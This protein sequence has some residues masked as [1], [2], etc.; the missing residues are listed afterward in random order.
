MFKKEYLSSYIKSAVIST[1]L[2]AIPMIVFLK[3]ADYHNTYWLYVGNFLFLLSIAVFV[4]SFNKDKGENASTQTL[5]AA[6]HI[7]T[8]F[9]ILLSVVVATIALVIFVPDIFSSGQSD[10]V[11]ENAPSVT[12]AGKTHGM[13]FMLYMNTIIGNF[14]GGSIASILIPITAKRNQ[15]KDRNSEVLNN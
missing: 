12:G 4:L 14:C 1:I 9:G 7:A 3:S 6:G 2:F 5:R 15:T 11:L 10:T 13:V 8:F